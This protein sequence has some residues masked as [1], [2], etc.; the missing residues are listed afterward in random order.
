MLL[1]SLKNK[2]IL[3]NCKSKPCFTISDLHPKLKLYGRRLRLNGRR[4]GR[5][6]CFKS[7]LSKA[8]VGSWHFI[9]SAHNPKVVG[10]NPAPAIKIIQVF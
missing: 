6:F 1:F 5:H 8:L 9:P 7:R 2:K 10:S 3:L 4:F